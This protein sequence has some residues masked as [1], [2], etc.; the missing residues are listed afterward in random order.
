[1]ANNKTGRTIL[2]LGKPDEA[3]N[4]GYSLEFEYS[5]S[6][7]DPEGSI[8]YSNIKFSGP[9]SWSDYSEGADYPFEEMR[10]ATTKRE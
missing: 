5:Y 9:G 2:Y 3:G 6:E 8:K 10:R 4:V 7:D 1:M